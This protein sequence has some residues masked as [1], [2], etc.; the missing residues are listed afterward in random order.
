M[1]E[2][3]FCDY[4]HAGM[5]SNEHHEKCVADQGVPVKTMAEVEMDLHLLIKD[6]HLPL[7][8]A[9]RELLV[10]TLTAA[11][12]G[13]VK[14]AQAGALRDAADAGWVAVTEYAERVQS[15]PP[16]GYLHNWLRAR[17]ASIEAP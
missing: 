1:S 16:V 4:C 7:S 14:E 3:Q 13:L 17:A 6:L 15:V 10:K 2:E 12:F 5:E 8:P 9:N 11:G